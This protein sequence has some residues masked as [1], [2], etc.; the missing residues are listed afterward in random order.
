MKSDSMK[1]NIG[2]K[3]LD[4]IEAIKG[5]GISDKD[6]DNMPVEEKIVS[7]SGKK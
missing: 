5:S 2:Q 4:G 6:T 7:I 3:I 1:R